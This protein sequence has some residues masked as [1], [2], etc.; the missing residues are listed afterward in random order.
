MNIQRKD[1]LMMKNEK[2]APTHIG[3]KRFV[4]GR[5]MRKTPRHILRRRDSSTDE[6]RERNPDAYRGEEIPSRDKKRE[7]RPD[8]YLGE[9]IRRRMKNGKDALTHIGTCK[10]SW[11]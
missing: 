8:A 9:E 7:G 1:S 4:D 11:R 6:K 5:K 3:E 10:D 2:D